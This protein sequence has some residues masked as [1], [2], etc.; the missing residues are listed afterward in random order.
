MAKFPRAFRSTAAFAAAVFVLVNCGLGVA[1]ALN[2]KAMKSS[3][4]NGVLQTI[5]SGI[6]QFKL[7]KRADVVLLGSSLV[8]A[9]VWT[10]DFKKLGLAAV[11]SFYTYHRFDMLAR[12][13][14]Q[15]RRQPLEVFSFAVP[16]AMVSDMY[17]VVEKLLADQ[18]APSL[19]IYGI[20]PR[21]F[22]DDL[23][24]GETKTA[25]FQRLGDVSDLNHSDFA[26]AGFDEKLELVMDRGFYLFGKRT[27][28][29]AKVDQCCRK[30]AERQITDRQSA[31]AKGG[32]VFATTAGVFPLLQDPKILW[33][34][35]V[36]EYHMRYQKF[37]Q[38]QFTKQE[39]FLRDTLSTCNKRGIQ[40]LLVNMP[41]TQANLDLMPPGLYDKY[42]Q[43]VRAI[44]RDNSVALLDLSADKFGNQCFYDTVHLNEIGAKELLGRLTTAIRDDG[45]GR[46]TASVA[47]KSL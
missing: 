42:L 12:A 35:S 46:L 43:S 2:S 1:A 40:V 7:S 47:E 20:A 30:I 10:A 25:V 6:Q 41:L 21:D 29:Q 9:P 19:V 37:N 39:Q 27:R 22:M 4:Q 38:H 33:R 45:G 16:G 3:D 23:A 32:D 34:K 24:A 5:D 11:G 18:K 8:M 13:L 28:Y 31:D 17:L 15:H 44:A 26:K 36:D 14:S